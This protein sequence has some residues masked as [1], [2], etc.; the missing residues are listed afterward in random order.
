MKILLNA[1]PPKSA[2]ICFSVDFRGHLW[3]FAKYD[4]NQQLFS[5]KSANGRAVDVSGLL[6]NTISEQS[7]KVHAVDFRGLFA[8]RK[9]A[10]VQSYYI[11]SLKVRGL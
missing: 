10:N 9:S 5:G 8:D 7:A 1:N 4:H 3:T 2:E 11:V 6:S